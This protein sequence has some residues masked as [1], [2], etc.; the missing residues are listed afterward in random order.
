M[1][2]TIF[3]R[4]GSKD[5]ITLPVF[6]DSL[7]NFLSLLKDMDASVSHDPRGSMSWEITS[8]Q[9]SSPPVVG[10]APHL[11]RGFRDLSEA[12]EVQIIDNVHLLSERGERNE[13]MSD[14]ALGRIDKLAKKTPKQGPMAIYVNGDGTPKQE[15][16]INERTLSCVQQ[17]TG[18]RYS[19]YGSVIGNLDSISVH[20]GNEFRIWD[21]T[22]NKPV[23]CKFKEGELEHVKSLLKQKVTVIGEIHSNSAGSP[24]SIDIEELV[25]AD[26]R[27]LPTIEEMSGLVEDFTE[28]KSLKEY[29]EDL[30]NE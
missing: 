6:I 5:R 3:L 21:E 9:K 26:Q 24:I 28:G 4:V 22:T 2:R 17:L 23:L 18:V 30:S 10:V 20:R 25:G 14:S 11:K 16:I 7:R 8:L 27:T 1:P 19:A 15:G 29:L 12:V 13:F